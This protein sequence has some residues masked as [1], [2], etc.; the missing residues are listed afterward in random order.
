[1]IECLT[2]WRDE[3]SGELQM[4]MKRDGIHTFESLI[5][6]RYQMSTQVYY[7]R[8]RRIYDLYLKRY[9]SSLESTEFDTPEK[10][11]AWNDVRAV[12]QLM[13]DAEDSGRPGHDWAVRIINRDHHRDVYS[14]EK[15]DGIQSVRHAKT[16]SQ[17]VQEEF[18]DVAFLEDLPDKPM[19]I[20]KIASHSD[21]DEKLIDFP[22]MDRGRRTSLGDKSQI[23]NDLSTKFRVGYIFAD[24]DDN[25][26][27][28][29]VERC[30]TIR[31]EL[32]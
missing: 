23:L 32:T 10:V 24:A 13:A 14:L 5:L 3:E 6:A 27:K 4:A 25:S 1:M 8:L 31:N 30:R 21:H 16:I 28:T 7:H 11:L 15:D 9:F 2:G 12:N 20:H 17:R 26:R 22:L 19:S 18:S 29:I